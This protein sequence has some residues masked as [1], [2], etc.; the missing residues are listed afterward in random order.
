MPVWFMMG[1]KGKPILVNLDVMSAIVA[2]EKTGN[3]IAVSISGA[4]LDIGE[5]FELVVADLTAPDEPAES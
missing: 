2:D 5:K 3:A 4:Q 1:T